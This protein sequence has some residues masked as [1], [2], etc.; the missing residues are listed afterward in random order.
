MMVSP[1]DVEIVVASRLLPVLKRSLNKFKLMSHD[2]H[3]SNYQ[4]LRRKFPWILLSK[5]SIKTILPRLAKETQVE[6]GQLGVNS[7][8][9]GAS[10]MLANNYS[11]LFISQLVQA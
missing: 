5:L 8:I 3:Q 10:A 4:G 2:H 11:L 9:L 7:I 6:I 1:V